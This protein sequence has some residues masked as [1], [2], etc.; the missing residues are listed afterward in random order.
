MKKFLG[1]I[2]Y[3]LYKSYKQDVLNN[4]IKR[5]KH[6]GK[7]VTIEKNTIINFCESI[8]IQD[9]VYIGPNAT[10]IGLGGLLIER[11]T[12][13]GPNVYIHTANHDFRSEQFIPYDYNY[14]NKK[15]TIGQNVWI[16]A[17]VNITP[18]SII[19]E[20]SIIGMGTVISGDIP[21]CSIVIGNPC[22]VVGMRNAEVYERLK[23]EDKIYLKDKLGKI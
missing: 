8:E 9:H 1:R 12:I 23:K 5:L 11:G 6:L 13:I 14:T 15:V 22:K 7:N 19:G 18:G 17:N 20:G 3:G 2:V 10:I 4:S 16:G 21:P